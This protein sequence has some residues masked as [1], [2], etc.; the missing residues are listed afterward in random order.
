MQ[1]VTS[2]IPVNRRV[3]REPSNSR[4][5]RLAFQ[6]IRFCFPGLRSALFEATRQ[7]FAIRLGR[8]G[9]I[10]LEEHCG[11]GCLRVRRGTVWLTGT[12]AE[13]D[14]VL[15]AGNR[16]NLSGQWPFVLQAMGDADIELLS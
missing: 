10:Q 11:A 6:L 15:Q 2:L 4:L 13:I 9:I 7:S 5:H 3:R 14:V 12:P 16:F 1:T 8:N